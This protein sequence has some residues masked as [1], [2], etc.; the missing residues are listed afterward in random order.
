MDQRPSGAM[1]ERVN[2]LRELR[3]SDHALDS[4]LSHIGRFAIDTLT[5][6]DAAGTSLVA[7]A[8][9]ATFGMTDDRIR[10]IDQRQYDQGN[11]P[12]V[13]AIRHGDTFYFTGTEVEPR[14]RQFAEAAGAEGIYSV[15]S[16]PM[17]ADGE[18]LGAL[19][20]YS[21]ERDA[22]RTGQREEGLMFASQ[23]AVTVANV[24]ELL[25]ARAQVDQLQDALKTRTVIGQATGLL[26]AQEGLTSE[27]AF[28]KLVH[29]SQTANLKLRD[30]AQRY[31]EAWERR[32]EKK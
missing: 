28:Q 27:E 16:L 18:T 7:G 9:V 11:G 13:D 22:L 19:N 24:K 20:L 3:L 5:G 31:V 14:W 1:A 12:C 8:E 26:M 25:D 21:R 30:V 4:L 10:P 17:K 15:L 2:S 29:V 23:A 32:T 6:W